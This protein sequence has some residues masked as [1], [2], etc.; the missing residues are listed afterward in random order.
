MGKKNK[1]KPI[2]QRESF[3][4]IDFVTP[5]KYLAFVSILAVVG[6]IFIVYTM[7]FNFGIDFAGGTEI[8]VQFAKDLEVGD[9]RSK[10]GETK[11]RG[12]Q[13]QKFDESENT[14]GYEFLIQFQNPKAKTEKE[15][16]ALLKD[17]IESVTSTVKSSY[18]LFSPVIRRVDSVGPRVGEQLKTQ[19]QLAIFYSLIVILLY[20]A[21]RFEFNYAL[22]AVVCLAHD[23]AITLGLLSFLGRE[24][25]IQILAAILTIIGYSLNDTIV[26]FDRVRENRAR[27]RDT[28]LGSIVNRSINEVLSR[29]VLTS[30]TTLVSLSSNSFARSS[31]K[32]NPA[33][34]LCPPKVV[35]RSDACS[36]T[37][38]K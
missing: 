14:N 32:L 22:A 13:I 16:N 33:A 29:T 3:G 12:A 21:L 7:G 38:T 9:L 8:Q 15:V 2:K 35:K 28:A 1:E 36:R 27:F 34:F 4:K 18:S 5:G 37:S 24:I 20:V 10:I 23:A 26:N 11:V 25:N 31:G 30:V 6:C 17:M 19:G